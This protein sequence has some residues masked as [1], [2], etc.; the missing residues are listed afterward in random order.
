M[1]E[2]KNYDAKLA[3]IEEKMTSMADSFSQMADLMERMV[4]LEER[5]VEQKS[6]VTRAHGKIEIL[7]DR[8]DKS[9]IKF[10]RFATIG[11][12]LVFVCSTSVPFI[13]LWI[14]GI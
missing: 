5:A 10:T 7:D 3:V 8:A 4:R 9:D 13:I 14:K 6:S 2:Q 11:A 12:V 1:A